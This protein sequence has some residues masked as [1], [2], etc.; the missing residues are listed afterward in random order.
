[1]A[2]LGGC[3]EKFVDEAVATISS[4]LLEVVESTPPEAA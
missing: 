3:T 4:L 1:M 2:G